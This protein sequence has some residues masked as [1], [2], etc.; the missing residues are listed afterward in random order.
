MLALA[1]GALC[2]LNQA[3]W[4]PELQ[5]EALSV[6]NCESRLD[7]NATN[8][9]QL[10][11]FQ[12]MG[13]TDGWQGWYQYFGYSEDDALDPVINAHVARL[14][15]QYDIDRG[16]DGWIQWPNCKPSASQTGY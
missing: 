6:A 8:G 10:G 9:N 11:L 14:I 4:E 1:A 13:H 15:Y 5:Q 12:I 2:W 3:G 7:P 16:Y